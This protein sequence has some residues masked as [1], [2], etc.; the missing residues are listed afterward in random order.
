MPE[1]ISAMLAKTSPFGTSAHKELDVSNQ[2]TCLGAHGTIGEQK[3][4]THYDQRDYADDD[5]EKGKIHFPTGRLYGRDK[6]LAELRSVY[7]KV[8][9]KLHVEAEQTEVQINV[10]GTA[11]ETTTIDDSKQTPPT[12]TTQIVFLGGLS[13]SGKSAL[14]DE[15][16]RSVTEEQNKAQRPERR[17]LCGSGKFVQFGEQSGAPFSALF[18]ALAGWTSQLLERAEEEEGDGTKE[19]RQ[20]RSNLKDAGLGPDD[21]GGKVLLGMFP[22]LSSLLLYADDEDEGKQTHSSQNGDKVSEKRPKVGD[23]GKRLSQSVL[24]RQSVRRQNVAS[25]D[26]LKIVLL[27]FVV[28][29]CRKHVRPVMMFIDDLQVSYRVVV[30]FWFN[31]YA[32]ILHT[33]PSHLIY[34]HTFYTPR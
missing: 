21:V 34:I 32:I 25:L 19:L 24:M 22:A 18:E 20:V 27:S 30:V 26:A 16:F 2:D 14:V 7:S 3:D 1:D 9:G 15:L 6:E 11:A 23:K 28:A 5:L 17:P 4:E 10:D 12:Q 13:G 33:S 29:L 31:F 8:E